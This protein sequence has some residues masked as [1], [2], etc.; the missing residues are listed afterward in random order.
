MTSIF[1]Q[2]QNAFVRDGQIVLG[3]VSNFS[4]CFSKHLVEFGS[5]L[6]CDS[7]ILEAIWNGKPRESCKPNAV[8]TRL[9]NHIM[10]YFDVND[11]ELAIYSMTENDA[12]RYQ[13]IMADEEDRIYTDLTKFFDLEEVSESDLEELKKIKPP[14]VEFEEYF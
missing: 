4:E 5:I 8:K 3:S 12:A 9:I 1:S 2:L 6:E 10:D 11:I 14:V 13:Q 7:P